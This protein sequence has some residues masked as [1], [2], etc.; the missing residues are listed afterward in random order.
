MQGY[1]I[2]YV[3]DLKARIEPTGC[4][5]EAALKAELP[6][7]DRLLIFKLLAAADD[8]R[9]ILELE[10]GRRDEERET[11]DAAILLRSLVEDEEEPADSDCWLLNAALHVEGRRPTSR[12][13]NLPEY[14]DDALGQGRR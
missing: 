2:R 10:L 13:G 12:M 9:R 3:E 11:L 14:F 5:I 7:M 1:I 4:S 8:L 6:R